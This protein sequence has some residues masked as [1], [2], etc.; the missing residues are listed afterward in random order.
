MSTTSV[1]SLPVPPII[2]PNVEPPNLLRSTSTM[3]LRRN[4]SAKLT[5]PVQDIF[6]RVF[7]SNAEGHAGRTSTSSL[8]SSPVCVDSGVSESE[9]VTRRSRFHSSTVSSCSS[10]SGAPD[11]PSMPVSRS[12]GNEGK[13]WS[14]HEHDNSY[15]TSTSILV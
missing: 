5:N 4:D 6:S 9:G 8:P 7:P 3:P 13:S 12:L 14:I 10:S 2:I 1:R 15:L 11:I